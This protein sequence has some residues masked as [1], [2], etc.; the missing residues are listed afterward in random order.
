MGLLMTADYVI[1]NFLEPIGGGEKQT[2][3]GISLFLL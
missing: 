1:Q 3:I 2:N